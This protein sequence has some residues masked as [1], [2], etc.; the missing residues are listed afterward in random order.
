MRVGVRSVRIFL[1][2]N[3]F[4]SWPIRY[5]FSK[6]KIFFSRISLYALWNRKK[7]VFKNVF[8]DRTGHEMNILHGTCFVRVHKFAF[9]QRVQVLLCTLV[10]FHVCL[11]SRRLRV[12]VCVCLYV[13]KVACNAEFWFWIVLTENLKPC[14]RKSRVYFVK[15]EPS[16]LSQSSSFSITYRNNKIRFF[17]AIFTFLFFFFFFLFG[18]GISLDFRVYRDISFITYYRRRQKSANLI[19]PVSN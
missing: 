11:S 4:N 14:S 3:N 12:C 1:Y 15:I 10:S 16:Y 17:K 13:S 8:C 7:N 18:K 2:G 5:I 6:E 19:Y 9:S